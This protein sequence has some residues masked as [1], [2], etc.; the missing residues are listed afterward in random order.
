[1]HTSHHTHNV[2]GTGSND[3]QKFDP[4]ASRETL[5]HSVMY[6]FAVALEDGSWHHVH[7]YSS[8]RAHRPSTVTLWHKISTVEDPLWTARY[9][10][11]DPNKKCFG[12]RVEILMSD[13]TKFEAE[14]L[15]A[16]AH[17]AGKRPFQREQYKH[18]FLTLTEGIVTPQETTHFFDA[19]DAL[20]TLEASQIAHLLPRVPASKLK[21]NIQGTTSI[22]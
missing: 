11:K 18:K 21:E 5:D 1:M 7:S 14:K 16:D 15:R 19:I 3:P 9:H 17:P 8:E 13:G 10:D 2:I 6:I 12:G 20:Y 4:D 22:F